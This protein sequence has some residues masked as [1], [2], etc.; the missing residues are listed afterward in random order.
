M[1]SL[2]GARV[3]N[4]QSLSINK[5]AD[6]N[7]TVVGVG[8]VNGDGRSDLLW[9]HVDG[10]LATW[11]LNGSRVTATYYLNPSRLSDPLWKVAG[12]K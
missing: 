8:D 2:D 1:W 7:W 12:P 10:T 11:W 6:P 9:Q 5:L 4:T 3:I